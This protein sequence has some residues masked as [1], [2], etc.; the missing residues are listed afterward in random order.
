MDYDSKK[1][2]GLSPVYYRD[3]AAAYNSCS[4]GM[5]LQYAER[6]ILPQFVDIAIV[7]NVISAGF[8]CMLLSLKHVPCLI[9]L[10]W[11]M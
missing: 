9:Y 7:L 6:S 10:K 5:T 2:G 8:S 4:F 3:Q 11:P 1:R